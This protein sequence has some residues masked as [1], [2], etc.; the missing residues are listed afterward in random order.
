M[1]DRISGTLALDPQRGILFFCA[2]RDDRNRRLR[3]DWR[4]LRMLLRGEGGRGPAPTDTELRTPESASQRLRLLERAHAV[5]HVSSI[6]GLRPR[7]GPGRSRGIELDLAGLPGRT[8]W[9]D[10]ARAAVQFQDCLTLLLENCYISWATLSRQ[11]ELAELTTMD[12]VRH[13]ANGFSRL[14][15]RNRDLFSPMAS[16]LP[17]EGVCLEWNYIDELLLTDAV[18]PAGV[19]P[20]TQFFSSGQVYSMMHVP[21]IPRPRH[22]DPFGQVEPLRTPAPATADASSAPAGAALS[23]VST[24]GSRAASSLQERQGIPSPGFVSQLSQLSQLGRRRGM[25]GEG[26]APSASAT[27]DSL[28]AGPVEGGSASFSGLPL[29]GTRVSARSPLLVPLTAEWQRG[30]LTNYDYILSL[31]FLAGRSLSDRSRYPIFPWIKHNPRSPV[32]WDFFDHC[33]D[34]GYCSSSMPRE[35]FLTLESGPLVQRAQHLIYMH[36]G[37]DDTFLGASSNVC[38][39]LVGGDARDLRYPTTASTFQLYVNT[40]CRYAKVIADKRVDDKVVFSCIPLSSEYMDALENASHPDSLDELGQIVEDTISA[41]SP[42]EL[43]GFAES[44]ASERRARLRKSYVE[45]ANLDPSWRSGYGLEGSKHRVRPSLASIASQASLASGDEDAQPSMDWIPRESEASGVSASTSARRARGTRRSGR[46]RSQ[47]SRAGTPDAL[48]PTNEAPA[49]AAPAESEERLSTA[50]L[51]LQGLSWLNDLDDAGGPDCSGTAP[52]GDSGTDPDSSSDQPSNHPTPQQ[53]L[54]VEYCSRH[55][56]PLEAVPDFFVPPTSSSDIS[57]AACY[58]A[59]VSPEAVRDVPRVMRRLL[60]SR[61]VTENLHHWVDLTFGVSQLS[62]RHCNVYP[63]SFYRADPAAPECTQST[64]GVLP[65][66]LFSAPSPRKVMPP[67]Q[68][69]SAARA[70]RLALPFPVTAGSEPRDRADPLESPSDDSSEGRA[71]AARAPPSYEFRYARVGFPIES[72]TVEFHGLTISPAEALEDR[73][74]PM[75]LSPVVTLSQADLGVAPASFCASNVAADGTVFLFGEAG[76]LALRARVLQE[77]LRELI[78]PDSGEA[79][80]AGAKAALLNQEAQIGMLCEEFAAREYSA[81]QKIPGASK[82]RQTPY[83]CYPIIS[84]AERREWLRSEL[85]WART[86]L[87][88]YFATLDV[89]LPHFLVASY[90]ECP[91][92]FDPRRRVYAIATP[93]VGS[94]Y[95][96]KDAGAAGVLSL[97]NIRAEGLFYCGPLQGHLAA[98]TCCACSQDGELVV[99]GSADH[100]LTLW[101][102]AGGFPPE[103]VAASSGRQSSLGMTQTQQSADSFFANDPSD[104]GRLNNQNT[105][106]SGWDDGVSAGPSAEE[107]SMRREMSGLLPFSREAG[108][109]A[110]LTEGMARL[111]AR[112]A[113]EKLDRVESSLGREGPSHGLLATGITSGTTSGLEDEYLRRAIDYHKATLRERDPVIRASLTDQAA[114]KLRSRLPEAQIYSGMIYLPD[115]LFSEESRIV[116]VDSVVRFVGLCPRCDLLYS[117]TDRNVLTLYTLSTLQANWSHVVDKKYTP[118]AAGFVEHASI[119]LVLCRR[120]AKTRAVD[121]SSID[122]YTDTML[123]P[124]ELWESE[125]SRQS[126]A[127]GEDGL[128][129]VGG[130]D[131]V[132]AAQEAFGKT[133]SGCSGGERG[134]QT[135][136][137]DQATEGTTASPTRSVRGPS[138]DFPTRPREPRS[139]LRFKHIS[140]RG[141]KL[142]QVDVPLEREVPERGY[143]CGCLCFL[144][145]TDRVVIHDLRLDSLGHCLFECVAASRIVSSVFSVQYQLL[146]VLTDLG[147]ELFQIPIGL[148]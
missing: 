3:G 11:R 59:D 90:A 12:L 100:S 87:H 58:L 141:E 111:A 133:R 43:P 92:K 76:Y 123:T 61:Y 31:N 63:E 116:H 128:S 35:Y 10:S 148:Q 102:I 94:Y 82:L 36:H 115:C 5:F 21:L 86:H 46:R 120:R 16:T 107:I 88:P 73:R 27:M 119:C 125:K 22:L 81:G 97:W 117:L 29:A 40:L 108:G 15:A 112:A 62:V 126:I 56:I 49:R 39:I 122:T 118:L 113:A 32:D 23:A 83:E 37:M 75:Q 47:A 51:G 101:R 44:A 9:F 26:R 109:E 79:S 66:Q 65:P 89:T 48:S 57:Y 74:R 7:A 137:A 95:V 110:S 50:P 33:G 114:G 42:D 103:D 134:E 130:L 71:S 68:Q 2:D 38:E 1:N 30:L 60:E 135:E 67:P 69:A 24:P 52:P 14:V 139:R 20:V 129:G 146:V 142:C 127:P 85:L 18:I 54:D 131:G 17:P 144:Q 41:R 106:E 53:L 140:L 64:R 45:P 34:L 99:L 55:G 80:S 84:P 105:I 72:P 91:Q 4:E 98:I 104:L 136:R 8:F 78:T 96:L 25:S 143:F 19:Q 93:S 13:Y 147:I 138:S 6:R 70:V 28:L 132:M 121:G 124:S 145:F 77:V